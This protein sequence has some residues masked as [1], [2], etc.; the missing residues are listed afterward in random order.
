MLYSNYKECQE[1]P[2]LDKKDI[3][4]CAIDLEYS[5]F[6]SNTNMTMYRN[7]MA[8]MVSILHFFYDEFFFIGMCKKIKICSSLF[9]F[10]TPI[11]FDFIC[12]LKEF[13]F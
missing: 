6:S 9:C 3:E 8:K 2:T 12:S 1:E 7:A 10:K 5:I 4:D 11:C 13:V